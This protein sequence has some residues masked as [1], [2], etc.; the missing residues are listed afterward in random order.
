MALLVM[1]LSQPLAPP[2]PSLSL[3]AAV[4]GALLTGALVFL[5]A[6]GAAALTRPSPGPA[7][8]AI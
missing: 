5:G 6:W 3:A 2:G 1:A 8:P 4:I 7:A